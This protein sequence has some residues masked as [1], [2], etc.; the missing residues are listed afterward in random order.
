M[1]AADGSPFRFGR[2]T[3]L[4]PFVRETI[5]V[6]VKDGNTFANAA[7]L[8]GIGRST[9]FEWMRRGRDARDRRAAGGHIG[10]ADL[11][12]IDYV[13]TLE[14]ADAWSEANAVEVI[15]DGILIKK[16]L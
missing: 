3:K 5:G 8:V 16:D 14:A 11:K 12:Y 2:P 1:A 15:R 10:K 6:F 7:R 9:H 13:E 4:T